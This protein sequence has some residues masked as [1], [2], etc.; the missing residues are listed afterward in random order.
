IPQRNIVGNNFALT[1][2]A[3][4]LIAATGPAAAGNADPATIFP[5]ATIPAKPT[6][7]VIAPVAVKAAIG[8]ASATVT[9][10]LPGT[11]VR[12]V[13]TT[14]GWALIAREGQK[15]GYVQSNALA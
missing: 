5:T 14:N 4:V 7:V 3:V 13:E 15:L 2:K 9:Q 12:L 6:H 11:Q 1:N 8:D 10:L